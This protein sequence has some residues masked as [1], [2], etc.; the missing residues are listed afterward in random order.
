M[1]TTTH[2]SPARQIFAARPVSRQLLATS[3]GPPY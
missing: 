1:R 3:A 2:Y